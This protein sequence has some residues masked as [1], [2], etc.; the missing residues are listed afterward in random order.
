MTHSRVKSA[1]G[2]NRFIASHNG[3]AILDSHTYCSVAGNE[4]SESKKQSSANSLQPVEHVCSIVAELCVSACTYVVSPDIT[5]EGW[6]AFASVSGDDTRSSSRVC[7]VH[8]EVLRISGYEALPLDDGIEVG[9][10]GF[11]VTCG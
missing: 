6:E 5:R 7:P 11:S 10:E 3:A 4:R 8:V 1:S 9:G 2:R